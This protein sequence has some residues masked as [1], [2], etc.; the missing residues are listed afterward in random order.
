MLSLGDADCLVVTEWTPVGAVRGLIDG[1]K[2]SDAETIKAF[3]QKRGYNYFYSVVCSHPHEDHAGG[4]IQL[5]KDPSFT[6]ST[7]WLHDLRNHVSPWDLRSSMSGSSPE[8]HGVKQVVETTRELA[9]AFASRGLLVQE[10]FAGADISFS[11][12]LTV[13]G[14]SLDFYKTVLAD[15]TKVQASAQAVPSSLWAAAPVPAGPVSPSLFEALLRQ[16]PPKYP[17]P[18]SL[19]APATGSV[20]VP[21]AGLLGNSSVKENPTTQPFNNTSVILGGTFR[22]NRLLFTADAGAEALDRVAPEWNALNWLQVPHHGS[23]GNLSQTNIERFR[24]KFANIS[25]CGD[26]SHPNRAIVSGLIKAGAQ[27]FSTHQSGNLCF[28]IG[29]VPYRPDY[30]PAV[31]LKGTG[32]PEP[33][34]DWSKVFLEYK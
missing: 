22:G 7:A 4:L 24:P 34:I 12:R 18:T 33:A 30:S 20:P 19:F 25:A 13:L 5:V 6:F 10:P 2:A 8:A 29:N 26:S 17:L 23:A 28:Y 15:F 16:P 32:S 3:L 11:P 21:L 14:P 31:P 1:G 27:V 9:S